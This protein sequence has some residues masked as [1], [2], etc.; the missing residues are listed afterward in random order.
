M[1]PRKPQSQGGYRC[2]Y[3]YVVKSLVEVPGNEAVA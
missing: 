1:K 2:M 3:L